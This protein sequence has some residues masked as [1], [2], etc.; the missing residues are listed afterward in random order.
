MEKSIES[1]SLMDEKSRRTLD[2]INNPYVNAI[3]EKYAA[4][5]KP[6]SIKILTD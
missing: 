2:E 5:C 6:S 1:I 3:I 4:I